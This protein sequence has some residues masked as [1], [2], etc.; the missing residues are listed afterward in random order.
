LGSEEILRLLVRE[1]AFYSFGVASI[2]EKK[3]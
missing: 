1:V 2:R 3:T